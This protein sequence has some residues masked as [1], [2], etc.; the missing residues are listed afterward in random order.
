[1]SSSRLARSLAITALFTGLDDI[2]GTPRPDGPG[3]HRRRLRARK[4][5]P[6][7]CSHGIDKDTRR[8]LDRWQ[9][10]RWAQRP[11]HLRMNYSDLVILRMS[12][13]LNRSW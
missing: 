9:P 13:R 2:F 8:W 10:K 7:V 6:P 5:T 4:V 3:N 12:A 11:R 1:M